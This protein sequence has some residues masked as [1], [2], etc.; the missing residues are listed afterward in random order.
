M[1]SMPGHW[2]DDAACKGHKMVYDTY[3]AHLVTA[4]SFDDAEM[5][6]N[7]LALCDLCPVLLRCRR[8]AL[9]LPDPAVDHVAGGMTPRQR[10]LRRGWT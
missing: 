8:W 4:L 2:A 5:E 6:R 3:D 7:A 1:G 10:M 9:T